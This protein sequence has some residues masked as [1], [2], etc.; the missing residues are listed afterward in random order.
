METVDHMSLN[1]VSRALTLIMTA[2]ERSREENIL[3]TNRSRMRKP[4]LLSLMSL[5]FTQ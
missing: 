1:P 2:M 5:K 4:L 3:M